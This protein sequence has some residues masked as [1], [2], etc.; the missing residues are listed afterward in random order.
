MCRLEAA[1]YNNSIYEPFQSPYK[2][3]QTARTVITRTPA[4][5][6][7]SIKVNNTLLC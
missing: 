1:L 3:D 5:T 6:H 4:R 7:G 2:E